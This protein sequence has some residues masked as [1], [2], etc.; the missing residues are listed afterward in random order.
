MMSEDVEKLEPHTSL[1]KTI[2]QLPKKLNTELPYNPGIQ[3][4]GIYPT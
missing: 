3:L 1:W 4:P 2:W